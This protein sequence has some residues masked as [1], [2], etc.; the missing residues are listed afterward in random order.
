MV[1]IPVK[2]PEPDF[3]TMAKVLS[4]EKKSDRV[5]SA[6][7]LIDEEIK[8]VI[9]EKYFRQENIPPPRAQRFGSGGNGKIED[10]C[11]FKKAYRD[12][13]KALIDFYRRLG[14][15]FIPD[16]ELYL[17]FSSL[18]SASR[19]GKDTAIFSRGE[20]YWAEEGFGMIRSWKDFEAFPWDSSE[21]MLEEYG[22]H[23]EFLSKNIPDGMKIASQAAVYEPVMEWLLGYEGL[24]FLAYDD[25][26]LVKAVIDKLAEIVYRSYIIAAQFK[27]V[28]VIWHGDDLG[29]KSGTMLS[30]QLLRKWIFPWYKKFG[31]VAKK[32]N[33]PYWYHCCGNKTEIMGD[34]I[35]Y[36][37]IDAL[38]AFEDGCCPVV[39]Y[40]EKYGKKLG[41]IGGADIDKLVR[42]D[43]DSLRRYL[44]DLLD[45]CMPGGRYVFGSGNSICNFIPVENY[46]V[47]LEVS[48]EWGK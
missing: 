40:K 10:S 33:K 45:R 27:E 24:F 30:P 6:E 11:E 36:V 46:L 20:R 23:L 12:Y 42:L 32:Y 37:G 34:L 2:N 13:H 31:E 28:G 3:D 4:G 7:L 9:V 14:Y 38:H 16:L 8:K 39:S 44:N 1:E 43:Q 47:M 35:D 15:H 18:N 29:Y 17:S 5:F 21:K 22:G 19:V 48:Q 41:L 26:D 25:P